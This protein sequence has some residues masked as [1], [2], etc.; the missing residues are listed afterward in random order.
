MIIPIA[1]HYSLIG[2]LCLLWF[3]AVSII[4]Y[5]YIAKE[6]KFIS[7]LLCSVHG[8]SILSALVLA[9]YAHQYK[10]TDQTHPF[11]YLFIGLFVASVLSMLYSTYKC[12]KNRYLHVIHGLTTILL[13]IFLLEGLMRIVPK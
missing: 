6:E 5:T 3:M 13:P 9:E 8:V 4:Y 2:S 10:G 7:R 11:V 1:W 12:E